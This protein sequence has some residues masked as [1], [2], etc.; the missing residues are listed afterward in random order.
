MTRM[1]TE[2]LTA[3]LLG[4]LT[5]GLA[6]V[7]QAQTT[8]FIVAQ[9]DTD[10]TGQFFHWGT[11]GTAYPIITW[12][13]AVNQTTTLGPNTPASGS[14]QWTIDWSV[15]PPDDQVMETYPFPDSAVLNLVNYT[16]ISFDIRFDPSSATDGLG[17]FG[18]VEVDWVP[19]SDG[20]PS[21][22][23]GTAFFSASNTNWVHVEMPFDAS[24]D[25]KLSAVTQV[26]F[27]IQQ[28]HTNAWLTGTSMF[29][30]D[31]V[32]LHGR[33]AT[34]SPPTV[35]LASVKTP[36]GLMVVAPGGGNGYRRG[37]IRTLDPVNGSPNY[38]WLGQGT[39]P[40]AYSLCI[41]SYPAGH[42]YFQSEIFLVPNGGN[43]TSVDYNAATVLALDI[44]NLPDGTASAKF[45]Y[46]INHPWANAEDYQPAVLVCSNGILGTWSMT[47]LNDTNVAVTAP[48]GAITNF[49]LPEAAAMEFY[50]PLSVYFGNQQNGTANAGQASTYSRV[51]IT[52]V[53][54]SPEIDETFAGPDLNP[55]PVNAKWKVVG[56]M[57]SCV[58]IVRPDHKWWVN[59][60]LPDTEFSLQGSPTLAAGSWLTDP[61]WTN[62]VNTA[63]GNRMLIP[64]SSLPS[65]PVSY[66]RMV[67]PGP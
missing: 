23:L 67:K 47:F 62:V 56:E 37:M 28:I 3:T 51:K 26:G 20:W 6:I 55:D 18:G 34:I 61:Q 24:T 32:I 1:R 17:S 60:T 19:Q 65:V 46:K 4:L 9:F 41:T 59:W 36:P 57:P 54:Q 63:L 10:T 5:A 29:W 14:A 30:V 27:K 25:P 11:W 49:A 7:G 35:S 66:F 38:S 58:F 12:D 15:D 64:E 40:V 52:G 48:N 21:K 53:T 42:Y 45:R 31:N 16:N 44:R 22:G 2:N 43:D 33:A 50:N 13:G 8:N 39:T